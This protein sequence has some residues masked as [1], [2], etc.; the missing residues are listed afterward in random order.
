MEEVLGRL[1]VCQLEI[2]GCHVPRLRGHVAAFSQPHM[3]TQAWSMAPS[4]HGRGVGEAN[5]VEV[6]FAGW[7]CNHPMD[8]E[9][10]SRFALFCDSCYFLP[11]AGWKNASFAKCNVEFAK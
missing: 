8:V 4:T 5:S 7:L 6:V 1:V 10:F 9:A 3:P 11:P 2:D